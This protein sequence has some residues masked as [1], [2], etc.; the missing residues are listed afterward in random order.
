MKKNRTV[1]EDIYFFA[2]INTILMMAYKEAKSA[3]NGMWSNKM[4][5]KENGFWFRRCK[6]TD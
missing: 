2:F 4:T 3:A 1:I 6:T 5:C